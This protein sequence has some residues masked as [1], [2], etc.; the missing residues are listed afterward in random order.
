MGLIVSELI[1]VLGRDRAISER[2]KDLGE[3]TIFLSARV[4]YRHLSRCSFLLGG[5]LE[6]LFDR[7]RSSPRNFT[8]ILTEPLYFRLFL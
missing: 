7:R 1:A 4:P 3:F 5:M 6:G 2:R 8:E